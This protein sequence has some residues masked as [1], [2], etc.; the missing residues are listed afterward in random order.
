MR[1][2]IK[3]WLDLYRNYLI[4]LAFLGIAI[5]IFWWF[6][7]HWEQNSDLITLL[8]IVFWISI[9]WL[10]QIRSKWLIILGLLFL[11]VIPLV[12]LFEEGLADQISVWLAVFL[13]LAILKEV[14][15]K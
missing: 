2:K 1:E 14:W 3:K 11:V 13:G 8:V 10:Y 5:D 6:L 12:S 15:Q 9:V 7:F 4:T